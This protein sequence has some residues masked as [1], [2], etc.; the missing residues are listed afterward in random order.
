MYSFLVI[1]PERADMKNSNERNLHTMIV[2]LHLNFSGQE[3]VFWNHFEVTVV[4]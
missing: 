2:F 1:I 4:S 3:G